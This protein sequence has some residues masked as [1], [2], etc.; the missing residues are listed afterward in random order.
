MNAAELR[1]HHPEDVAVRE[2]FARV[3]RR[4]PEELGMRMV[5]TSATTPRRSRSTSSTGS[6]PVRR[7]PEGRDAGVPGGAPADAGSVPRSLPARDR[8]LEH[9]DVL[10]VP[11]GTDEGMG[12]A[13]GS[14]CHGAGRGGV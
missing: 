2:T 4:T 9:G 13:F 5:T 6:P 3:L 1:V 12:R 10:Y 8:R 7:P 11:V 14:T